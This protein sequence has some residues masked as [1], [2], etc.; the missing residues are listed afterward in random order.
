LFKLFIYIGIVILGIAGALLFHP[1]DLLWLGIAFIITMVL[2]FAGEKWARLAG[3]VF[4]SGLCYLAAFAWLSPLRLGLLPFTIS[5]ICLWLLFI[6]LAIINLLSVSLAFRQGFF[7]GFSREFIW[8]WFIA[9]GFLLIAIVMNLILSA[10]PQLL[11][12][13]LAIMALLGFVGFRYLPSAGK[14]WFIPIVAVIVLTLGGGRMLYGGY[15]GSTVW[16][17]S[18]ELKSDPNSVER[19]EKLECLI[20]YDREYKLDLAEFCV[21][22]GDLEQAAEALE[23]SQLLR[24]DQGHYDAINSAMALLRGHWGMARLYQDMAIDMDARGNPELWQETATRLGIDPVDIK[25]MLSA[26]NERWWDAAVALE[27][28]ADP[29]H[30][31]LIGRLY[32]EGNH[33]KE[34]RERLSVVAAQDNLDGITAQLTLDQLV[35]GTRKISWQAMERNGGMEVHAGWNISYDGV[36]TD[37]EIAAGDRIWVM[38]LGWGARGIWPV[39]DVWVDGELFQQVYVEGHLYWAYLLEPIP[40]DRHTIKLSF[41]NDISVEGSFDRNLTLDGI[42]IV[43]MPE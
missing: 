28:Q 20:P 6:L 39:M 9:L 27:S 42:Y 16:K 14:G 7:T 3:A 35:S 22:M 26:H 36:T 4:L 19:L 30:S 33:Q 10:S 32:W 40:T 21:Q 15:L 23:R 38:A 31:L 13:I 29:S 37:I 41:A 5:D 17:A 1:V 11:P 2:R 25:A 34:A 8:A 43:N 24:G 18:E 12:L